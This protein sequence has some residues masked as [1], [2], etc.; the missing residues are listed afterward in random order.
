MNSDAAEAALGLLELT[1]P[2]LQPAATII[3]L[4]RKQPAVSSLPNVEDPTSE[5]I[6]CICGFTYDDGFS[7]ACDDCSRWCHAACFGIVEG[8]VPEEW[9]CW[10]C[11]PREVDRERAVKVQRAR[12]KALQEQAEGD[13]HR[14]RASPGVERKHRRATTVGVEG[15]GQAGKRKRRLS[16]NA[17]HTTEDELVDIGDPWTHSYVPITHDIIPHQDTRNRLKR[18]AQQWRGVTAL[19]PITSLDSTP[20]TLPRDSFLASSTTAIQPLS[21]SSF[22]HPT[23]SLNTN[24]SVRPPSYALHATSPIPSEHFIAPYTSTIT[25]SAS[26]LSDPLNAYAHIGMPKPFVHLLQPPFDFALDSRITGNQSRFARSGCRPNAVLRPVLCARG[27]QQ[28]ESLS[29]G[30]FALR[31]IHAHEEVVLGWEWDDGNAVH[32]LPALIEAPNTFPCAF[33]PNGHSSPRQVEHLRAQMSNIIHS[34]TSTFTTCACGA[35]AKDCA[36]TQMAAFV[37]GELDSYTAPPV[38]LGPLVGRQRGFK[39]RE[40][41]PFSGGMCGVEQCDDAVSGNY[42]IR[43]H[44]DI[45]ERSLTTPEATS[46]QTSFEALHAP[47]PI[48]ALPQIIHS[49]A[50]LPPSQSTSPPVLPRRPPELHTTDMNIDIVAEDQMPPKMRKRWIHQ[51]SD[52]LRDPNAFNSASPSGSIVSLGSAYSGEAGHSGHSQGGISEDILHIDGHVSSMPPPPVPPPRDPAV[53]DSISLSLASCSSPRQSM[54]NI[55]STSPSSSFAQL[56][57]LS[58]LIPGYKPFSPPPAIPPFEPYQES[59]DSPDSQS[60][61]S[62]DIEDTHMPSPPPAVQPERSE[63]DSAL[64]HEHKVRFATPPLPLSLTR[65]PAEESCAQDTPSSLSS[66]LPAQR[67]ENAH[68]IGLGIIS[69][70]CSPSLTA[71]GV[72][73][74]PVSVMDGEQKAVSSPPTIDVGRPA[75]I[76]PEPPPA[77]K[78]KMSLRDFA[79]R[80]KRQREEEL[81]RQHEAPS[82]SSACVRADEVMTSSIDSSAP[83]TDIPSRLDETPDPTPCRSVSPQE[84]KKEISVAPPLLPLNQDAT[85]RFDDSSS[86]TPHS[87][88]KENNCNGISHVVSPLAKVENPE[89]SPFVEP[90]PMGDSSMMVEV[91]ERCSRSP[92]PTESPRARSLS[93]V[94]SLKSHSRRASQ[95]DGEIVGNYDDAP[96]PALPVHPKQ[97]SFI[98]RSHT[99]PTQ[100]RSFHAAPSS[101]IASSSSSS[102]RRP[103]QPLPNYTRPS[104]SSQPGPSNSRPPPSGPR[105]LR[106]PSYGA[107]FPPPRAPAGPQYI[108]RGPSADRD[109]SD[110]DRE[111]AWQGAPRPRGRVYDVFFVT[112]QIATSTS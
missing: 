34:L 24:P 104:P 39:T 74:T 87:N 59:P 85:L 76:S 57:L 27:G 82:Q 1:N 81:A 25:P 99:P 66:S 17:P 42:G 83:A 16:I 93:P 20:I 26:Y 65:I 36:L 23:L 62:I 110:W 29:F 9:R 86:P 79:L 73:E 75:P 38:D 43:G 77:P 37:D 35:K 112:V 63:D 32:S 11:V 105:A 102:A 41:V 101:P 70:P 8:S 98:P 22:S 67:L 5:A 92:L 40:R 108:P 2:H 88:G 60:T 45:R 91:G 18:Q 50:R 97:T 12:L 7:I 96:P 47:R 58:P 44:P 3:P 21:P 107:G 80:K 56:S 31:D 46:R 103:S 6:N 109:R 54:S 90:K 84:V 94:P 111:R 106:G 68:P 4:K 69:P 28:E 13:R 30:V 10:E 53:V 89:T 48:K 14:R 55:P 33:A 95:E 15:G 78:V 49:Q 51:A 61:T 100:P 72:L 19:S 71:N 52:S 64:A